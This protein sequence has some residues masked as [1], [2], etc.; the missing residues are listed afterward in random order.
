MFVLLCGLTVA[1]VRA[2]DWPT[3]RH[4]NRRSGVTIESLTF[5]LETA[6]EYRAGEAPQT[7]WAGPA[8]WDSYADIRK[9]KSMRN[10]D[11][12]F[13]VTIADGC[14]T[15]GSSVDDAVHCL[16]A[17]TGQEKWVAFTGGPVRLPPSYCQGKLY[18]GS[19]DGCAYCVDA[20]T[21]EI[22]WSHQA[23]R[24]DERIPINSKLTSLFPCRTGVLVQD[25]KAYF[26]ASL[27]PW[28]KTYVCALDAETG[29]ARGRSGLYKAEYE[30]LA[31]QG[32]MLASS[33]K[34]YL[35]QG[36]QVPVVLE[37]DSGRLLKRMGSSGFG[38][39][40]G[41]LTEDDMFVHGHGQNH[42]TEGE[43]RFFNNQAND[44]LVTYPRATAIVIRAGIVYLHADG[45][46]QAFDRD[47]YVDLQAQIDAL[48]QRR[49]KL[50][51]QRKKL[52]DD[53][54]AADRKR[55]D[56]EIESIRGQVAILE[57]RLPSCFIW[58]MPS[59]CP[60]ELILAGEILVAGGEDKV[61]A[62]NV[63]TGREVWTASVEGRAYGLAVAG[64]RLFVST[65]LGRIACFAV[66]PDQTASA[67]W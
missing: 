63:A 51:K 6:W 55:L 9:L 19:D 62:Y 60:L 41:L 54:D 67:Q 53:A 36:R 18:F 61:A 37:R 7:A 30:H 64:G 32:P 3:Y 1:G 10:F 2:E 31:A 22:V 39:V 45:Q 8:K 21:G 40:F 38:G 33:T 25:S 14:L 28:E 16:E 20:G 13:H 26:A 23:V 35:S 15:F 42:R 49:E 59:D 4:D 43:L 11:P 66:A 58:Q 24:H 44:R 52:G 27:L 47:T 48:G 29:A 34:L 65:D 56:D 46:L 12:V 5:P 57:E 50:Q 17:P